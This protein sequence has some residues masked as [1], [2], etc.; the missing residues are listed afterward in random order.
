MKNPTNP[1]RLRPKSKPIKLEEI[2]LEPDAW[3]KF[4]K[5]IR[6]AAKT[7]PARRVVF[8]QSQTVVYD[9]PTGVAYAVETNET[10]NAAG[11]SDPFFSLSFAEFKKNEP[12]APLA[13]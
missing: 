4:E 1:P 7:P 11:K 2:D 10:L 5:L 12:G 6:A 13:P 8:G 9:D 3:P